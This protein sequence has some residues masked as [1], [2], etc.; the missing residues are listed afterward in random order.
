MKSIKYRKFRRSKTKFRTQYIQG[1][2][3]T[4]GSVIPGSALA[5]TDVERNL[6]RKLDVHH[7]EHSVGE[8]IFCELR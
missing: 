2:G 8:Y 6:G 3:S 1:T 4:K 7:K 5:L